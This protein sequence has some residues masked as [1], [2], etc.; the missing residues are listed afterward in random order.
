MEV[1]LPD[2]VKLV[3]LGLLAL[4][5]GFGGL[6][7][8]LPGVG[9]LQV[10]RLPGA[11]VSD[12]ESRQHRR[13][14]NRLAAVKII[15]LGLVLPVLY[16]LMTFMRFDNLKALPTILVAAASLVCLAIGIAGLVRNR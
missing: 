14:A 15:L 2:P 6:A 7:R 1:F 3:L 9:W 8:A 5:L 10:F 16:V 13:S 11:R 12:E 4:A